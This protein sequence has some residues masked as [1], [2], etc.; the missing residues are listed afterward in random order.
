MVGRGGEG[1]HVGQGLALPLDVSVRWEGMLL[2][3]SEVV[4]RPVLD[5][6]GVAPLVLDEDWE[7]MKREMGPII[8]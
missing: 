8:Y 6:E 2:V 5:V 3:D 4:V 1:W 7:A